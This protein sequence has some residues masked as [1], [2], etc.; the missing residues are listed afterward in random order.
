MTSEA[1]HYRDNDIECIWIQPE[2]AKG[3][4]NS[5]PRF[6]D[7]KH[8]RKETKRKPKE[9]HTMKDSKR[10]GCTTCAAAAAASSIAG[11]RLTSGH[12]SQHGTSQTVKLCGAIAIASQGVG[13]QPRNDSVTAT[14]TTND[15][16]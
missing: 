2:T 3:K 6:R 5:A 1:T 4:H 15:M 11:K 14:I 9:H 7:K 8:A 16:L 12:G 13:Q 10:T